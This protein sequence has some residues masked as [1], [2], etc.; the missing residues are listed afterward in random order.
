MAWARHG[1]PVFP[2]NGRFSPMNGPMADDARPSSRTSAWRADPGAE[3]WPPHGRRNPR[4]GRATTSVG[5]VSEV[6]PRGPPVRRSFNGWLSQNHERHAR[7]VKLLIA[8]R[9]RSLSH[10][11]AGHSLGSRSSARH[12]SRPLTDASR[13]C[14]ARARCAS[15]GERRRRGSRIRACVPCF[16][17]VGDVA[18]HLNSV[19]RGRRL[20]ACRGHAPKASLSR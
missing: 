7:R 20:A 17:P 16:P 13:E 1:S 9:A 19:D 6:Y 8:L 18:G 14:V 15:R 5:K 11:A 2:M 3:H 4:F 10:G 12:C